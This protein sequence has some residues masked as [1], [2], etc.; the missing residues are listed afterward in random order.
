MAPIVRERTASV[1]SDETGGLKLDL[2]KL[3]F[4][5]DAGIGSRASLGLLVLETDQTVEHEFR[6][7]LPQTS[8]ALYCARLHNEP[9]ITPASLQLM[10]YEIAPAAR[11]LPPAVALASVGYACT[12]GAL[13][14]GESRVA[15]Q[16]SSVRQGSKITDPVTAAKAALTT[17][18]V[19]RVALLTPYL[20]DINLSL[21]ASFEKRGLNIPVMGS[22]NEPNDNIVAR[23][24]AA[25]IRNA[26]ITLGQSSECDGVF[27]SC[28]SL[29]VAELAA[30]V[31]H[32][33]GKPVTSS[34]HA[35]AWHML[36]LAG[37]GEQAPQ[38]GRLFTRG[39]V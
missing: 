3:E 20:R 31:E 28:T 36:R 17:L 23:I 29:R 1:P 13:F 10:E 14:I 22:F 5:V 6:R 16:I 32:E 30:E 4:N 38:H 19:Q 18:N 27:V 34:N 8:V 9:V 37:V 33:L 24:S 15:D 25:S 35:L 21:R 11:L 2:Q 12:S 7:L 39:L 26:I